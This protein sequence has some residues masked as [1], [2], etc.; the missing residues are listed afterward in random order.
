MTNNSELACRSCGH[1]GLEPV[2]SLGRTPLADAL[3]TEEQLDSPELIVP[4]DWVFCPNCA[5]VQITESVSPAILFGKDYPYFSSVSESLLRHFRE[6]AEELIETRDL[7]SQ[8]M[9]VE[10]ASNDGYM[11]RN[12]AEREIPVLGIDPAEGP[13]EA[14]RDKGIP[15]LCTF[16]G[17][18][19]ARRLRD[20][21]GLSADLFLAKPRNQPSRGLADRL[22]PLNLI[23]VGV[24]CHNDR[25]TIRQCLI[26]RLERLAPE[27]YRADFFC[28]LNEKLRIGSG[29]PVGRYFVRTTSN[30]SVS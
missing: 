8:S 3:L 7:D 16:F 5:L 29:C 15:T 28:F 27:Y 10:A 14:A 20:E 26:E 4:L 9:V 30:L 6:S 13:A 12:F 18:E 17:E 19:L 21:E 11:L 24:A 22:N 23:S 2:L 1:T 25:A